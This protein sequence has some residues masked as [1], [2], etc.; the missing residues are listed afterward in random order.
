MG[1]EYAE[2][3][4]KSV[5]FRNN[6][7]AF[8]VILSKTLPVYYWKEFGITAV[9]LYIIALYELIYTGNLYVYLWNGANFRFYACCIFAKN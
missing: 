9:F 3:S 5:H 7:A 4:L 2:Y 8:S 6:A 1:H